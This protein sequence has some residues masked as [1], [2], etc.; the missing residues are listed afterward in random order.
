ML[1]IHNEMVEKL[2][3]MPE[4]ID[5]LEHAFRQLPSG[6]AIH[7]PRLDMYV[8][9]EREDGYYRWGTME[10]ANDGIFAI[11]MKS[12][13]MTW[14]KNASGGWRENKYCVQ[15]GLYCG[16][17]LL[18]STRN[19][20]P[21]AI[22]NDGLLQHMRVGAGAGIGAKHLSRRDAQSVGMLGSGGMARTFLEAFCAVRPIKR[23]KVF[24]P[25]RANCELYAQE[26]GEKLGI[27]VTPV[28]SARE[29]VRGVDILSTCTDSMSPTFDAQWLEPGMH[30]ANL[31]P[32]E[33]SREALAGFDVKI[34]QGVGGL[35]LAES[36]RVRS[37]VGHSPV[38]F[39]AGTEEEMRRLPE[40]TGASGFGGDYPDY[41]D[42]VFGRVPGRRSD[43]EITFYH[44]VGNQGLQ[45]SA[46]GGLVYRKARA[47]GMG[48]ELPTEWFLQDIRD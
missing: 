4:C 22:I 19:G 9:C 7:R 29:A 44:N 45:F 16:L 25:T 40:P 32:A 11:R 8:P 36:D 42:L 27:E 33:V 1:F 3:S 30:V 47:V 31:G 20:E 43:Q 34:R 37:E 38:A 41:C 21:L 26:M 28:D 46:A 17:I 6:G 15:P 48:R 2:L 12:D 5:A 35:K 24:S 14:P 39:I 23:V 18:F 13:L 10:G